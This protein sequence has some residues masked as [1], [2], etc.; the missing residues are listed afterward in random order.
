MADT[1]TGTA[2]AAPLCERFAVADVDSHV[3]RLASRN[4]VGVYY[5]LLYPNILGSAA[6]SS[7]KT[8]MYR[9]EPSER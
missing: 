2:A 9:L 5:Q 4:E 1:T 7:L 8:A 6:R 3:I